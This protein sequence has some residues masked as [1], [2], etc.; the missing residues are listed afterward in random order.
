M[1]EL[2]EESRGEERTQ[3]IH[4]LQALVW[5]I[6]LSGV[7]FGLGFLAGSRWGEQRVSDVGRARV[8]RLMPPSVEVRPPGGEVHQA[9]EGETGGEVWGILTGKEGPPPAA[10]GQGPTRPKAQEGL[11]KAQPPQ[12]PVPNQKEASPVQGP[13]AASSSQGV[14]A[15]SPRYGLQ[16]ISV[17]G[18]EKA[19]S[20]ARELSGK[21]YPSPRI[22]PAELPGRGT[23]YRVRVGPFE[24][25]EEAE[26]W[27]KQIRDRERMQPQIVRD[28][29]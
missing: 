10:E 7:M 19:E 9:E 6:F 26:S 23:W 15:G 16:V 27:A 13:S 14:R 21:G 12:W 1:E 17:Q 18:R 3:G 24:T 2:E 25:K 4:W 20:I 11:L 8:T 28:R 29:D 22:V 5:G